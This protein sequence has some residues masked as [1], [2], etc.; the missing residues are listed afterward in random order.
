MCPV[1]TET[2][3]DEE[4]LQ[5]TVTPREAAV[6]VYDPRRPCVAVNL[7][8][9]VD[10]MRPTAGLTEHYRRRS[11]A[12]PL[13]VR[14]M[15]LCMPYQLRG[16]CEYGRQC[17]HAHV[18]RCHLQRL[19]RIVERLFVGSRALCCW[20]HGDRLAMSAYQRT[21]LR[22]CVF[23]SRWRMRGESA[24]TIAYSGGSSSTW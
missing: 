10:R 3:D 18:D 5:A 15:C 8:I 17:R 4:L 23:L 14:P 2:W 9:D 16:R 12:S 11:R 6:L 24:S 13:L 7:W 21:R 20:T 22:L 1:R 19:R